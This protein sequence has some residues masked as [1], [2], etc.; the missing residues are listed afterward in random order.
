MVKYYTQARINGEAR[1]A[2]K[3][4]CPEAVRIAAAITASKASAARLRRIKALGGRASPARG[5]FPYFS[6]ARQDDGDGEHDE[7]EPARAG[8]VKGGSGDEQDDGNQAKDD[9]GVDGHGSFPSFIP[10]W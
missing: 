9:V 4:V 10:G 1:T 3:L 7:P 5:S 6:A 2:W 8:I